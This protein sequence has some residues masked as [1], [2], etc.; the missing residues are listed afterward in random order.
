MTDVYGLILAG[1]K[2][3]RMGRDKALLPFHGM[4]QREFLFQMLSSVCTRVFTS[5]RND[6]QVPV[7]L[8]PIVDQLS[9]HSPLNGILSAMSVYPTK[10]WLTVPVDMPLVTSD[11][12]QVLIN[13]RDPSCVATC[14]YDSDGVEPEPLLT[15]WEPSAFEPLQDY[16][17]RGGFS[18][19]KFLQ[20]QK[21]KLL[22][23]PDPKMLTNINT[24]EEWNV[25][26]ANNTG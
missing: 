25:W 22:R 20:R 21:V 17:R 18:P 1:G 23:V 4:P 8:H 9:L 3:E 13:E 26:L 10:A 14:F 7:Q 24:L 16:Q 11:T 5:C 12:I 6:Q 15:I 2:S 19:K